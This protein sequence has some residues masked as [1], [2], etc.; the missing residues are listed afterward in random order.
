MKKVTFLSAAALIMMLGLS[1]AAFAQPGGGYGQGRYPQPAPD[2]RQRPAPAAPVI[3]IDADGRRNTVR[4]YS[5]NN[6]DFQQGFDR[7]QRKRLEKRYGFV[8]PLVMYVPD[9]FVNRWGDY[10]YQGGLVYHKG[11]DGYFHLDSRYY[12]DRWD[13]Y[14]YNDRR[15]DGRWNN[16]RNRY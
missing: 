11:R 4:D 3:I 5:F 6:S 15:D 9:R 14:S 10:V 16:N 1:N 7:K 2:Y 13:D 8:P 12:N